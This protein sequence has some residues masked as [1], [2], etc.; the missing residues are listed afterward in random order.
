LEV[1]SF[2]SS[3]V[4]FFLLLLSKGK[5]GTMCR[6]ETEEKAISSLP[7]MGNPFHIQTANPDT[8]EDAKKYLLAGVLYSCLL[9]GYARA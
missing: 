1:V 4:G 9:K 5:M 7:H 2:I 6:V 8:I 3:Y